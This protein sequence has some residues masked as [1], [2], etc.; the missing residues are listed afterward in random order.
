MTF[1]DGNTI[2]YPLVGINVVAHEVSHGFT[3]QNS[4]LIYAN[5]SGGI[6]EAFSD[7]TGEAAEQYMRG[8]VDWLGAADITKTTTALRYFENPTLDGLSIANASQYFPGLDV[9]YSSGVYNRAY[10]LLSST[11]GWTPRKAFEIFAHANQNYWGPSETYETA[12]CGVLESAQDFFYD[13]RDVDTAFQAVGVACG[14]LPL[15]DTSFPSDRPSPSVSV[16]SGSVPW[17]STSSRSDR[18]SPSLS[19]LLGSVP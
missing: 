1:G 13:A 18:L 16:L 6:N 12:A 7:I 5:Q 4:N 2:F 3:E 17:T 19:G 10:F 9:H 15:T 14:Y 8:N 11:P